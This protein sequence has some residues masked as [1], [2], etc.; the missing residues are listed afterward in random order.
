M[1]TR[2]PNPQRAHGVVTG[3]LSSLRTGGALATVRDDSGNEIDNVHTITFPGTLVAEGET[4]EAIVNI[5][6]TNILAPDATITA[7]KDAGN[8]TFN[9]SS[10][11]ENIIKEGSTYYCPYYV[12]G[13]ADIRLATASNRDGPWTAYDGTPLLE[14]ADV[15][16]AGTSTTMYAP[17]IVKH[18]DTFYLVYSMVISGGATLPTN[19]IGLATC[20]TIDGD[21][22]DSGAPILAPAAAG[23]WDSR[24]VGEPSLLF[25]GGQWL[26]AYMGEDSDFAFGESEKIGIATAP[27]PTGPWT[28]AAGNPIIDFG[29]SGE[30]DDEVVADPFLFFYEGYYWIWYCAGP[31]TPITRIDEGLAYATDPG[32]PWTRYSGNPI[33]EVGASGE[34]DDER[35]FRG[36]LLFED[37]EWSGTY[38]AYDGANWKGGNFRLNI[39]GVV[40]ED[41]V[42][43]EDVPIDDTGGYYSGTNVESMGQEIGARLAVLESPTST[44]HYEVIVTGNPAEAVLTADS[45]D[46]VYGFVPD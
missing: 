29:A 46:W 16:W 25:H 18:E 43:A 10:I 30:W 27:T 26:L 3:H 8:P 15:S 36:G 34:W 14:L 44:G 32:G 2:N 17:E 45:L 19:A 22:V 21:Y 41:P 9:F 4:G 12:P 6:E 40:T 28:R 13:T 7:A 23:A 33:L 31:D 1:R 5:G 20:A 37:G 39:T 11:P 35:V 42:R 24:R 38:A